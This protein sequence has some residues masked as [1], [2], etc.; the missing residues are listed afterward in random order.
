MADMSILQDAP[1]FPVPYVCSLRSA[2]ITAT[3]T[4]SNLVIYPMGKIWKKMIKE[5]RKMWINIDLGV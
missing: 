4:D 3:G 2:I 5:S 1:T